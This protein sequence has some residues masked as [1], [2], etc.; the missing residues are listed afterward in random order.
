MWKRDVLREKAHIHCVISRFAHDQ[1]R[2]LTPDEFLIGRGS[3]SFVSE[4]SCI[5]LPRA[6]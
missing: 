3:G 2:M 1:V 6:I 5:A 4:I